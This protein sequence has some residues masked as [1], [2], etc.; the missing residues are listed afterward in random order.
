MLSKATVLEI[1]RMLAGRIYSQRKI[2]LLCGVCRG[3]VSQI[4]TG[5]RV[6]KEHL[7]YESDGPDGPAVRCPGCGGMVFMPCRLCTLREQLGPVGLSV[8]R[9]R[10]GGEDSFLFVGL[11]LDLKSESRA[12]FEEVREWRQYCKAHDIEIQFQA[13]KLEELKAGGLNQ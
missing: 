11:G 8:S 7:D 3:T 12:R 2:A 6:L 9:R 1:E 10:F 13:G 4:A 5:R